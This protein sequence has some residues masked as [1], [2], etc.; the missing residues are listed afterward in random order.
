MMKKLL[1]FLI[2]LIIPIV[3]ATYGY[4]EFTDDEYINFKET[5]EDYDGTPCT[6]CTVN[7]T[8]YNPDGTFNLSCY[9]STLYNASG[10]YNCSFGYLHI[11]NGSTAIY[12]LS[13]LANHSGYNGTS[14]LTSITI[15]DRYPL[16][17]S[18][19]EIAVVFILAAIAFGLIFLYDHLP[20][21]HTSLKLLFL[22]IAL[23]I[24]LLQANI[25][26]SII[27]V[28]GLGSANE[29]SLVN[30]SNRLYIM[31]I[32]TFV[33]TMVYFLLKFLTM[34]L[35]KMRPDKFGGELKY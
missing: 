6:E 23:L 35:V 19:W 29:S 12:P 26:T 15:W 13:I 31:M 24:L 34:I 18:M 32:Y 1:F 3:S 21:E 22:M 27:E 4:D 14:D 9:P 10:I 30:K 20:T 7:I 28:S 11:Y 16:D 17:P 8:L 2:L 33:I 5:V 25:I